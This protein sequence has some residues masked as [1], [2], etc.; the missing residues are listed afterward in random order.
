[1]LLFRINLLLLLVL[2]GAGPLRALEWQNPVI[3]AR[4]EPFQKTLTLVFQFKNAG[5]RPV[6]LL[7]LQPSCSCLEATS[8][9]KVYAAG[10]SGS[11][12]AVFSAAETP[13][14]YE[15]HI[16]VVTDVS[17]PPENL[18]VRIE[19]PEL[20]TLVP[21][22]VEWRLG[23]PAAEKNIELR[24]EG[25]LQIAFTQATPTNDSFAVHLEA[26]V[27]DRVYRL[28]LTPRNTDAVANAAI[29]ISGHDRAGHDILVSAY[30][31]VR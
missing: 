8:D 13:G 16:R 11:V 1:M 20:A 21:R 9:K 7:D 5:A 19:I 6:H 28:T 29:R 23:E 18:T 12:T 31:N 15:R 14:I 26:V 24:A 22:S 3:E 4:A 2:L 17:T 25:S 30:A 10:E 27:P